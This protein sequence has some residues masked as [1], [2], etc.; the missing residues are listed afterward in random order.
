MKTAVRALFLLGIALAAAVVWREPL[1]RRV[2]AFLVEHDPEVPSDAI[3]VL[4]GSLPDRVLHGVDLW[5]AGLAPLLVLTRETEL[6]G[7]AELRA[8]GLD[9]PERHEL[10]REIVRQLGVPDEAVVAIE[11]RAGSTVTEVAAL[12]PEL[13]KRGV[14]S[15]LLVTS[16]THARRAAAIFRAQAGDAVEVR[17]SPTPHDPF[18]ADGWWRRREMARR[19]FTE[20]GK[21]INF[22]LVDRWRAF[23][24][25]P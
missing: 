11:E 3:V 5:R 2:G 8:R 7:L 18:S 6:P 17:V 24:A 23:R 15:I 22:L 20:Y 4:S 25:K 19:V 12:L 10:N 14:R 16:K 13:R 9:I 1:L 21:W